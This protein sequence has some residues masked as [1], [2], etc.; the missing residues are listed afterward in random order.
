MNNKI[1][2]KVIYE[3]LNKQEHKEY[4]NKILQA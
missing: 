2:K 1:D 3:N 4:C